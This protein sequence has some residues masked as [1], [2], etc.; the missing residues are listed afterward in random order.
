MK[1]KHYIEKLKEELTD[2][3]EKGVDNLQ[4][5]ELKK[6]EEIFCE[7]VEE[8]EDFAPVYNKMGVISIYRED[9]SQ[10]REHLQKA[11]KIDEEF[12]PALTN[13][14]SINKKEGNNERAKELY[15]LAIE[16]DE[17]YGPAYNNLGVIYREEKKYR[18]SVKYLKK[19]QKKGSYSVKTDVDKPFYK[20]AGCLI[21]LIL[22]ILGGVFLYYL[23]T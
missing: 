2:K 1:E 10:A 6:A 19:A 21:P 17:D 14:G 20:D 22:L 15:Q 7:V 11:L 13:L 8:T 23:F 18:E 3:Y 4:R 5:G 12:P 16:I 9:L